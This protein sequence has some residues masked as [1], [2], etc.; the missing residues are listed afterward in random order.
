MG[1]TAI[2]AVMPPCQFPHVEQVPAAYDAATHSG[3][4]AYVCEDHFKTQTSGQLGTGKGQKLILAGDAAT[5]EADRKKAARDA[6]E[7]GDWEAFEEAV[8]DGDP[9]DFM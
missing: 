4:W 6:L 9:I 2:V 5:S 1:T 7:A 3:Q 8:G